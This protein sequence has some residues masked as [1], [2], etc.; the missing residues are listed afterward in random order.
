MRSFKCFNEKHVIAYK[1]LRPRD[2]P[3]NL[4]K[5][6]DDEDSETEDV[7]NGIRYL[8]LHLEKALAEVPR[9][10]RY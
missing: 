5:G 9:P 2:L 10:R 7:E 1:G 4:T 6:D 8:Q 3:Y